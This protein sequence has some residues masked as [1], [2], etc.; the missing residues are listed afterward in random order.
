VRDFAPREPAP[1]AAP[2]RRVQRRTDMPVPDHDAEA[3]PADPRASSLGVA[4]LR[5]QLARERAERTGV[6][7]ALPPDSP[8]LAERV[9]DGPGDQRAAA[10]LRQFAHERAAEQAE[11]VNLRHAS[12]SPIPMRRRDDGSDAAVN[13]PVPL[14]RAAGEPLAGPAPTVVERQAEV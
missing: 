10:L 5:R 9:T 14:A 1:E 7:A 11:G 12:P 3:A 8:A 4:R 6:P 13:G 2:V